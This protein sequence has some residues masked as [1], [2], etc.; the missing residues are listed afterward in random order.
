MIRVGLLKLYYVHYTQ[1]QQHSF[2]PVHKYDRWM[3]GSLFL[4]YLYY[5]S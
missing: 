1:H 5:L 2:V 4:H 3:Y